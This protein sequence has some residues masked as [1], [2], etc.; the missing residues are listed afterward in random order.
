MTPA[1]CVT[2]GTT[3]ALDAV[4]SCTVRASQPGNADDWLPAP[5]VDASVTVKLPPF[6]TSDGANLGRYALNGPI[7]SMVM[8]PATGITYIGGSFSEIG[9]RSGSVAHVNG[10]ASGTDTLKAGSPDVI[11]SELKTFPDDATGYF[12]TGH[13]GSVN[14]DGVLRDIASRLTIDGKVDTSW[15]LHTTC[16][17][18]ELPNWARFAVQWDLG[19]VLVSN[20]NMSPTTSGDSTMGLAFISKATGLAKRT[21]AG[22]ATCGGGG[23]IWP[24][25]TVFPPLASCA[26]WQI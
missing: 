3:L 6:V 23:R 16:G 5:A 22:N 12:V 18:A 15:S 20:I 19:D 10:P 2:D 14:G 7:Q 17:T 8:D 26:G 25:T 9:V 11:G 24:N 1:I 21:G 4:G 13:I